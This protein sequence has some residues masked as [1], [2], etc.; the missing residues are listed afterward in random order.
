MGRED[1]LIP[2]K[3][4]QSGNPNGRPKKWQTDL[5][6]GGY[7]KL[8][9]NECYATLLGQTEEELIAIR[10]NK[11]LDILIRKTAKAL[12]KEWEKGTIYNQETMITRLHG[13]PKQEIEAQV[14]IT[15][16]KVKF[17]D[18]NNIPEGGL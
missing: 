11:D 17:N 2:F 10:D 14:N 9:I 5:I 15:A 6:Q 8:Q 1:N 4:G 18:G 13:Q 12:L 7:T 16:F 3:P